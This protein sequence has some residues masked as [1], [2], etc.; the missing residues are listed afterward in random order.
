M[1][2]PPDGFIAE[3]AVKRVVEGIQG[4]DNLPVPVSFRNQLFKNRLH[5]AGIPVFRQRGHRAD[6]AVPDP[7][8]VQ[9]GFIVV[10]DNPGHHLSV[11][12]KRTPVFIL[13]LQALFP[14]LFRIIHVHVKS[15]RGN[16]VRL[17][18]FFRFQ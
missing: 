7:L 8:S 11:F 6:S 17:K 2:L 15:H 10:I 16:Q 4:G 12:G 1:I 13:A 9:A 14:V 3:F 18:M 5:G